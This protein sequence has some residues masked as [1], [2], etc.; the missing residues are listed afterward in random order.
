VKNIGKP[1]VP[2]PARAIER[3]VM[4]LTLSRTPVAVFRRIHQHNEIE[5]SII[6]GGALTTL[7][8]DRRYARRPNRLAVCWGA[9]PHGAIR[10]TNG[11]P[12]AYSLHIPLAL[13]NSWKLPETLVARV[14]HGQLIE[15]RPQTA[16]CPDLA[17]L[18]HWRRLL[19]ENDSP[20]R[21]IVLH[22]IQ[23]RLR[24]LARS[25]RGVP[26]SDRTTPPVRSN[27]DARSF[28]KMLA[29]IHARHPSPLSVRQIAQA[30]GI[31]PDHA[32]HVFREVCG[33][34]IHEH[35]IQCRIFTA[36]RLLTTTDEKVAA[37]GQAS[38]FRSS[39]CFH[40]AF[41]RICG[42]TPRRYRETIRRAKGDRTD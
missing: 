1:A 15:D 41:K 19:A 18:Q 31:G 29:M 32:M 12:I 11:R 40:S 33:V 7:F 36:Q 28:E 8:G 30:A 42:C 23:A 9:V 16:P 10:T 26:P 27:R 38:G 34:T 39:D 14:L 3:A 13:F 20:A 25:L 35:L 37:I 4:G 2:S 6:A 21:E 22:E 24:R 17:L 5:V